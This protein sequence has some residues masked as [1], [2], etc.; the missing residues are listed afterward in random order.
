MITKNLTMH[1]KKGDGTSKTISAPNL[2]YSK[3][4]QKL[5]IRCTFWFNTGSR[6]IENKFRGC[7]FLFLATAG[8]SNPAGHYPY[9][10]PNPEGQS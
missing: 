9:P 7:F 5:R 8:G 10:F 2:K 6:I 3:L 4:K 1:E